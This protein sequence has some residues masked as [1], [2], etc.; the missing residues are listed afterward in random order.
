MQRIFSLL[1][2][3][4][5][6]G[7]GIYF[8][9][10]GPFRP[11]RENAPSTEEVAYYESVLQQARVGA[12]TASLIAYLEQHSLSDAELLFPE[13]LVRQ[14]G[15]DQFDERENASKKLAR[16]SGRVRPLLRQ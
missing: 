14:L 10:T 13:R 16:L 6:L 11:N 2:L 15:S 4:G 3:L 9:V 8:C 1:L 7:S 5:L 12:D